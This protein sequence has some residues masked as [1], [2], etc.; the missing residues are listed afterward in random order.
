MQQSRLQTIECF[1]SRVRRA[2]DSVLVGSDGR[3]HAQRV[4]TLIRMPELSTRHISR[5]AL[6]S[7][8]LPLRLQGWRRILGS[9]GV[10]RP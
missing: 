5:R 6:A 7:A 10:G 2:A 1:C 8:D 9:I 3:Q 4:T